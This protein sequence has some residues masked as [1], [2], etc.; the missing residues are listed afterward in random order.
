MNRSIASRCL[1]C[2]ACGCCTSCTS[3]GPS[4]PSPTP[5]TSRRRPSRSS[6]RCSSGRPGVPLLERAGRGVRLTDPAL[7]L[8]GHAAALLERAALAEAEL[9]AAAGTVAGRGRGSRVPVG[10]TAPR[11]P[12]DRALAR[13]APG[14]RCELVEAEPET[15]LP[16]LALGDV[17]LVLA[18]EWQHQPQRGRPASSA[19]TSPATPFASCCPRRIRSPAGTPDVARWPRSPAPSGRPATPAPAGTR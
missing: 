12:G 11:G 10:R 17:D 15:S 6:S 19:T 9:A 4:P 3:A 16:A 8:V 7:V 13:E 18:D 1:I 14:L 5:S 2:A